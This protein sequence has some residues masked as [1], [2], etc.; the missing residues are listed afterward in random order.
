MGSRVWTLPS[1]TA[2]SGALNFDEGEADARP[3]NGPAGGDLSGTYPSPNV[4]ALHSGATRLAIGSVPDG[5]FLVRNGAS[6][7]GVTPG[8]AGDVVNSIDNA[9]VIALHTGVQQLGIGAIADGQYLARSG[10]NLVGVAAPSGGGGA[11]GNVY[12]DAPSSPNAL[13]DEFKTGSSA[14]N[15]AGGRGF[16]C[17]N[18]ATGATMTRVGDVLQAAPAL[19]ANEYRSTLTASGMYIQAGSGMVIY[20]PVSGSLAV[21]V[22][23]RLNNVAGP[24]SAWMFEGPC[25]F[26]VAP[27]INNTTRRLF[28]NAYGAS[29]GR[30]FT[31]MDLNQTYTIFGSVGFNGGSWDGMWGSWLNW[32]DSTKATRAVVVNPSSERYALDLSNTFAGFTPMGAGVYFVTPNQ[33]ECWVCL[34]TFRV[35]P[36]GVLPGI[37]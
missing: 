30:N 29:P 2:Y 28:V 31:K 10:V 4:S 21:Y 33:A 23:M 17:V 25:L 6:I 9:Q 27:V 24:N 26:G 22:D 1:V 20:K 8:L 18:G 36:V 13:N 32:N 7:I 34:R 19:G 3:P 15:G 12:F 11:S 16:S 37:A 5:Q 35:Y 14:L